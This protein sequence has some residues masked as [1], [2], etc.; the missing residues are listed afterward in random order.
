MIKGIL[1]T[2]SIIILVALVGLAIWRGIVFATSGDDRDE[3]ED[4][5]VERIKSKYQNELN[6]HS[7]WD[8]DYKDVKRKLTLQM[9]E[10]IKEYKSTHK[11]VRKGKVSFFVLLPSAVAVLAFTICVP[12]SFHQVEAGTVAVVKELG[13]IVD[14][15]TPG[16]YFD[17][18]MTKKYEIYDTT[19][20]QVQIKTASYSNDAQT[21]NLELYLQYQIQ[22]DKLIV[23]DE[24][25]NIIQNE[26]IAG[27]YVTLDSLQARIVTQCMDITKSVMG[28]PH[29]YNPLTHEGEDSYTDEHGHIVNPG[30][31]IDKNGNWTSVPV[32][33]DNDFAMRGE[34]IIKHRGDVS[35]KVSKTVRDAID[36]DFYVTVHDVVLT[37]IDFTDE[38]EKSVED[39]V[40]A[41]QEKQAAITRAEAELEVARIEAQK[42]IAEAEGDAQAQLIAAEAA[43]KAA[44][45]KIIELA[46]TLGY[47]I[48]ETTDA[49]GI[50]TYKII[51]PDGKEELFKQLVLDYLEYLAYLE[52]WNGEL[53]TVVSGDNALSIIVPG[54]N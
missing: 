16:T 17:F 24:K 3:Y 14:V 20:Q 31:F 26:G 38:F 25:G 4:R 34:E 22:L 15:R 52:Q 49:E 1:L 43:A 33:P 37:N 39:K 46:R 32:Y 45:A 47:E 53:P 48:Q 30:D 54:N 29:F 18:H 42:K 19:V 12:S 51:I 41:E 50:T 23:K 6:K 8:N 40:I 44:T 35:K 9:Q 27:K 10:E 28:A 11:Y 2:F 21:M 7:S 36:S 5:G 13:K